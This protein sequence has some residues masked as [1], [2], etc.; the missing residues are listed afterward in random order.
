MCGTDDS[1]SHSCNLSPAPLDSNG[2]AF[3]RAIF[4]PVGGSA[5]CTPGKWVT[6]EIE[7]SSEKFHEACEQHGDGV[8]EK[9]PDGELHFTSHTYCSKNITL[10]DTCIT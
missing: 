2:I 10:S 8:S 9:L 5:R 6:T 4:Q 7:A 3:F 1:A